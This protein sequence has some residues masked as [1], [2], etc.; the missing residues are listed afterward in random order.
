MGVLTASL[1]PGVVVNPCRKEQEDLLPQPKGYQI[2]ETETVESRLV[3]TQRIDFRRL[4]PRGQ[5]E[6]PGE[7]GDLRK[8]QEFSVEHSDDYMLGLTFSL[9]EAGRLRRPAGKIVLS[10]GMEELGSSPWTRLVL[11]LELFSSGS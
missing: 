6:R 9:S 10:E 3:P 8:S 1:T 11:D 2:R 5:S 4:G 7:D